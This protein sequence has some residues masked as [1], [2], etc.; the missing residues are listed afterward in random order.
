MSS[1]PVHHQRT[2]HI[3][4][5]LHFVREKVSIGEVKVLHVPSSREFADIFTKGL[6]ASLFDE[7]HCSMNIQPRRGGAVSN[8]HCIVIP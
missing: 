5:D 2:K 3:E 1:N 7:F 4:I 6:H 8:Y